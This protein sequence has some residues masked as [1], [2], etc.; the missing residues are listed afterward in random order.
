MAI[1]NET[2]GSTEDVLTGVEDCEFCGGKPRFG[3]Y[4]SAAG[5]YLGYSCCSPYSRESGYFTSREE[6]ENAKDSFTPR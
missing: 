1:E 3:V 5:Y 6:A 4:R 2:T